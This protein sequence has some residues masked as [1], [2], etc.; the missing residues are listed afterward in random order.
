MRIRE[1]Q[2]KKIIL[3]EI[4]NLL[5][6]QLELE[7]EPYP[8]AGWETLRSGFTGDIIH[9]PRTANN[10]YIPAGYQPSETYRERHLGGQEGYESAVRWADEPVQQHLQGM[11]GGDA[12]AAREGGFALGRHGQYM[13]YQG[14]GTVL[15]QRFGAEREGQPRTTGAPVGRLE[16]QPPQALPPVPEFTYGEFT[17]DEYGQFRQPSLSYEREAD[18]EYN[19]NAAREAFESAYEETDDA[20]R[21]RYHQRLQGEPA[22]AVEPEPAPVERREAPQAATPLPPLAS[23]H[24]HPPESVDQSRAASANVV[25]DSANNR[26]SF[27]D[28]YGDPVD[29][30]SHTAESADRF[31]QGGSQVNDLIQDD[32]GNWLLL[33][34]A[35]YPPEEGGRH[36]RSAYV[37]Y[38]ADY[39][40]LARGTGRAEL[41]ESFS[42][43]NALKIAVD[44][45]INK[46]LMGK[47]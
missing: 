5:N 29:L 42:R 31:L 46:F 4:R 47:N 14:A 1:S 36:G 25:E 37:W 16:P 30:T 39:S 10:P 32:A 23:Y 22:A 7:E 41:Q 17:P 8:E 33:R 20:S 24:E 34:F 13:P 9:D 38:P 27:T 43:N 6:E 40:N 12:A 15:N 3:E 18:P 19:P 26:I 44:E 28:V 45:E 2:L 21:E 11:F 35:T